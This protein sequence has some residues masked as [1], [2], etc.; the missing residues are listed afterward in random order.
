LSIVVVTL[1]EADRMH[2]LLPA[3]I[4]Q[5]QPGDELI[6]SDNGSTDGT[7]DV[8]AE[9]A[10]DAVI[11]RNGGNVGFAAGCNR[12]AEAARGDVLVLLNPDTIPQPGWADALR[13]PRG[14]WAAWQALL[15]QAHGT[16]VNTSGGIV[17]FTGIAWAGQADEPVERALRE[18][19]EVGFVSGACLALPLSTWREQGGFDEDYF[20][21]HEDTELSLRLR[22]E[23]G[24]VGIEPAAVVEHD[25]EF[26]RNKTKWRLLERNRWFTLIRTYPGALLALLAPALLA[27][28]LALLVA[29]A[30]GGWLPQKLAAWGDV[31]RALP[32]VV[33]QRRAIQARRTVSAREFADGLVAGLDSQYLGRAAVLSP[34]LRAYWA[35]VRALLR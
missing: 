19:R 35:L 22:L 23:G 14:D 33:R 6:I 30:A 11:V 29:A 5:L 20:A 28:E 2:K 21:Y 17:H 10:P 1:R 15:T 31:V 24:S 9:L 25:Y 8:V 26:S 3:L 34:L 27:T 4:P 13:R 7:L 16:Q 12:G 32:R 18:P